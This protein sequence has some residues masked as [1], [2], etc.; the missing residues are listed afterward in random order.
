MLLYSFIIGEDF[1]TSHIT[2][3]VPAN[4][5]FFEVPYFL[6]V[7][8]DNIDEEDKSFAIVAK[9]GPD[10]PDEVSCFQIATGDTDCHGRQGATEV[11]IRDNDSKH[12]HSKI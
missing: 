2:V 5:Q 1:S 11:R 12:I 7:V 9:I 6:S 10:V 8:D 4:T 3:T